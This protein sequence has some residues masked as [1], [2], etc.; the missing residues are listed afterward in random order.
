MNLESLETI[1]KIESAKIK[2][3][4]EAIEKAKEQYLAENCKFEIGERVA[5][6]TESYTYSDRKIPG[7]TE[8]AYIR[9]MKVDF[10][11]N[12]KAKIL[13]D[14]FAEKADGT[15]SKK[16]RYLGGNPSKIN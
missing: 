5:I 7:Y 4:R 3:S 9:G 16:G 2:E 8:Y 1:F 10:N 6:I 11:Y 13:Y 15:P 12:G 14:Y